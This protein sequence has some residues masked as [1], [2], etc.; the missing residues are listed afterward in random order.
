M[1]EKIAY[2]GIRILDK[3]TEKHAKIFT[4]INLAFA[5]LKDGKVIIKDEENIKYLEKIRKFNPN[6]KLV[7]SI[8]G[9]GAFGFSDMAMTK[10]TRK[11][12]LDSMLEVI[13]KYKLDGID[14]D[15]EFPC[16]DWGGDFSPKDKENFTTLLKEMREN[17]DS[18][19]DKKYILSIAAGVGQW[20][21]DT[22]EVSIYH[23]Y[24]DDIMLMT[25]DLRGFGQEITGHH[26]AL[27]TKKDDIFRMS[28]RDGVKL[29]ENQG[30]PKE[31]IVI[32]FAQYSRYWEGV[33]NINKGLLQK[34]KPNGGDYYF[35]YPELNMEVIENPK[36]ESFWDDEAKVP[37]SYSKD[38]I[39]VTYDN[40]K[41]VEEKAKFVLEENLKGL[42]FWQYVDWNENPLLE[43]MNKILS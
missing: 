18:I 7:L 21:I 23:K 32:G 15:W 1:K 2:A 30:V 17:L 3:I 41:S 42:M 20:F 43:A 14:L 22:T 29:L 40:A 38:G 34:A 19:G 10:E 28:A 31:K 11:I 25:Y 36:F 39:F 6:I 35:S 24:L 33:E 12:F 9:A 8:G 13:K 16:A 4:R 27:N 37:W 26:T 5:T